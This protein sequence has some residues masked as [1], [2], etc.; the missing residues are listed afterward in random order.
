M[1]TIPR[2]VS[3]CGNRDDPVETTRRLLVNAKK[4]ELKAYLLG[5]LHD[6]TFNKIHQ[7]WRFSQSN[8]GWL[9]FLQF[10][11]KQLDHKSWIYRE[12][13]TRSVWILETTVKISQLQTESKS[14]KIMYARGYFDAEGGMPKKNTDF[15][16]FQFCQK[17]KSDLEKVRSCLKEL[18]IECGSI[19][20]PSKRIDRDYWRFFVNR[21]SHLKFMRMIYSFHP[22]KM[23][24]MDVR[25]KI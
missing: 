14:E 19:H 11:L 20:N 23:R 8:I 5:A 6:A 9:K 2:E 18:G 1:R 3:R 15:L 16:Y 22:R 10:L 17:D 25:M 12:G 24:Q 7:T 4:S 13:K 21:K